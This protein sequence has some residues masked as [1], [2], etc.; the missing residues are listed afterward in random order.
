MSETM[1]TN[2][3][4]TQVNQGQ[5]N[6][7]NQ[8]AQTQPLNNN[9]VFDVNNLPPEF[10][11]YVDQQRTQASQTA[12][13][14]AR[15]ELMGDE[16][17]LDE[18]RNRMK[19]QV[20]QTVEQQ[21]EQLRRETYIDRSTAKVERVLAKAGLSEED[22]AIYMPMLVSEDVD[23]SIQAAENFVSAFNKTVE[24]RI[25]QQTKRDMQNMTTPTVNNN[26]IS[27]QQRLQAAYDA[28][29][30]DTSYRK[31]ATMSAITREAAEKGIVL[32]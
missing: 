17:F 4:Q 2:Q 22:M 14:N 24:N 31:F 9:V 18:I 21:L 5:T 11:R 27:E 29:K 16:S 26:S 28:A 15:K 32:K 7:V 12:R 8:Q 1:Q 23:A 6:Q 19:P 3:N 30:K 13:N 25:A 20:E 10:Q